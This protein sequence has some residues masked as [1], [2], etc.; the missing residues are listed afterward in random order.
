MKEVQ[1]DLQTASNAELEAALLAIQHAKD[2]RKQLNTEL[3]SYHLKHIKDNLDDA[4]IDSDD[5][6]HHHVPEFSLEHLELYLNYL[7][8]IE[9]DGKLLE[10]KTEL[11]ARVKNKI[12]V[13]NDKGTERSGD[14]YGHEHEGASYIKTPIGRRRQ[15][16]VMLFLNLLTGP[17]INLFIVFAIWLLVPFGTLIVLGYISWMFYDNKTTTVP[18]FD[19]TSQSWRRSSYFQH[20]RDFFP[21]RLLKMSIHKDLDA[22]KNYLFCY[23]PHGVQSAGALST[24]TAATGFDELF[25]GLTLSLQTL[26]V[27][28]F[29][30][31]SR[32]T[33]M[34]LGMGD[35][36]KPSLTRALTHGPG[37]S[38]MLVTG[39]A[40]ESM[41][42]SPYSSKVV[43]K[44]R[45]GFVKI[46]LK[47][48]ASLVPVWGFG[49][50]NLYENLALNSPRVLEFQRKVQKMLTFAPLWVAGRG[51]FSYSG[52]LLPRR[53]PITVV[54]GD[55]IPVQK[56]TEHDDQDTIN[57]RV[58]ETHARYKAA[59]LELFNK[60]K[61]IYDPK[62][63]PIEFI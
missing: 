18:N 34:G 14:R 25:P 27:N 43:L 54:V 20:F 60:H 15:T 33:I 56:L 19:R 58:R 51:V 39:G 41:Y 16:C 62:A 26:K 37:H 8:R 63:E 57:K 32:E 4:K 11:M 46:A 24:A 47:T 44:T 31:I 45:A 6:D 9:P 38:A 28:W 5:L 10:E 59:V 55:P 49:E 35:A 23:H 42:A 17:T 40:K 12:K 3:I 29:I 52:G 21:I 53:R 48:G 61:D 7:L 2:E 22:K 50:N 36:S 1:L 13:K 30:P